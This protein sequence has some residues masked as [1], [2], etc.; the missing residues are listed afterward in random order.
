MLHCRLLILVYTHTQNISITSVSKDKLNLLP[1]W[2]ITVFLIYEM[3]YKLMEE[4]I[5]SVFVTNKG[6]WS[7]FLSKFTLAEYQFETGHQILVNSST[8]VAT[9]SIKSQ[10]IFLRLWNLF[11][12]L[13]VSVMRLATAF[14]DNGSIWNT[15]LKS[16]ISTYSPSPQSPPRHL[17]FTN[18]G[19]EQKSVQTFRVP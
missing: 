4:V 5:Q 1:S 6:L 14:S 15:V 18:F 8:F 2:G 16:S 7:D 12:F 17:Q 3:L 10:R 19:F 9:P 13:P 11:N